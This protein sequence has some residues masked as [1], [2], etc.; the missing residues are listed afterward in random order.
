MNTKKLFW[1]KGPCSTALCYILNREFGHPKEAEEYAADPFNGGIM[2]LGYQCGML[3]GASLAVGAE[4]Y[5]RYPDHNL[6][7]GVAIRATQYLLDSFYNK[8][9][10]IICRDITRYDTN[11]KCGMMKFLLTG[12][13]ISC[14]NLAARWA[15]EAILAAQEGLVT[16]PVI[17]PDLPVSCASLVVKKMGASEEE[18]VMVAGFAGGL[19]LSGNACGG[20]GAAI[21]MKT[22]AYCK[23]HPGNPPYPNTGAIR[24]L[25]KFKDQTGNEFRCDKIAG[26]YFKNQRDH[27]DYLKR[28]GCSIL[29]E[30]LAQS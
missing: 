18:M 5:R 6:A 7:M 28:G 26:Q 12:K 14:M 30:I 4:A 16:V 10:T 17:L 1:S 27:S 13:P 15:P 19:G 11:N 29:M 23:D 21:W 3:W 2:Q 8:K 22:L 9:N 24:I 20:L 25:E